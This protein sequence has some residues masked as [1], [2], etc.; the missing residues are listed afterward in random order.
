MRLVSGRFGVP[1]STDTWKGRE[2]I[3]SYVSA[4]ECPSLAKRQCIIRDT[5]YEKLYQACHVWFL[6]QRSKG[7]PVLGLVLREKAMQ[8]FALRYPDL[9][10]DSFKASSGWLY[11]QIL[12]QTWN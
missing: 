2:K 3:E 10:V 8:L 12:S 4:S 9:S 7:A 11:I 5:N 6:Q 1:K